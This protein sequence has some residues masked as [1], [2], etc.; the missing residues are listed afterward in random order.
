[1][2]KKVRLNLPKTK[3]RWSTTSGQPGD[4]QYD[5]IFKEI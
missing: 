3:Y 1:M 2:L 4:L 5:V